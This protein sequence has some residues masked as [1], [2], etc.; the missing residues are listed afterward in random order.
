MGSLSPGNSILAPFWTK[1][2]AAIPYTSF[3]FAG[4]AYSINLFQLVAAGIITAFQ[5]KQS[6]AFTGPGILT[7]TV[8]LG[9]LG[10]T[11]KY[12]APFDIL[13]APGDTVYQLNAG[14]FEENAGA[15]TQIIITA[16]TTGAN[17]NALTTGALDV[18]AQVSVAT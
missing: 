6:A 18:W 4:L 8:E 17:L 5:V 10:N 16:R 1:V 3:A 15:A 12:S 11:A 9:I 7:C 14:P 13:Q 2:G